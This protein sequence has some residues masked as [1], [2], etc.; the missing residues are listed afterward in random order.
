[1]AAPEGMPSSALRVLEE[2]LGVG[3]TTAGD[4][5]DAVAAEGAYY[6]EQVTITEA[7]EDDYEYEEIPDDNFSIP[8]GEEDL[9][10]AIHM[11]QEQAIDTQILI[12]GLQATLK[13][14]ETEHSVYTPEIRVVPNCEKEN[15][16]E[17]PTQKGLR[18]AREQNKCKTKMKDNTKNVSSTRAGIFICFIHCCRLSARNMTGKYRICTYLVWLCR[19]YTSS[20][21]IDGELCRV[22]V[23]ANDNL[24]NLTQQRIEMCLHLWVCSLAPLPRA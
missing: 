5:A 9:A 8:E 16:L 1:M 7:S 14:M 6:L 22:L 19:N 23:L 11:V 18:E 3:L 13:H 2:A 10:K 12:Y 17:G 20:L 4:T 21:I 24:R 15:E